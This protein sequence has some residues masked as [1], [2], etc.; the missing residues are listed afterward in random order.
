[1]I[2]ASPQS[3]AVVAERCQ[4]I[5]IEHLS[6]TIVELWLAPARPFLH[7]P[8]QYVV[9]EGPAGEAPPRSY[10]IGG[11]ARADG[12]LSL[13]ITDV[14]DGQT[15]KWIH[16][17]LKPGEHVEISGPYGSFLDDAGRAAPRLLL[18]AGS[19]LAP[20]RALI[21]AALTEHGDAGGAVT[22]LFSAR[23]EADVIDRDRFER[24]QREH[25]RFR[26]I[27]TLTREDGPPPHGRVPTLLPGLLGDLCAHHVYIAGS[28]GF[29]AACGDAA[30]ALGIPRTHLHT[31]PFFAEPEPW[32]APPKPPAKEVP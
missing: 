5:S 22:L 27:R 1:M 26:F 4:V 19:G 23:A 32:Q 6:S 12:L 24:W 18:A 9:L 8:G 13:L 10:S 15:S 31:E 7:L 3:P 21:E 16:A 17:R 11:T 29:V 30:L 20:I 28:A 25:R 14:P 2:G